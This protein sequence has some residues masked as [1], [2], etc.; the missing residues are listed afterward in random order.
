[1]MGIC[2]LGL[3]AQN[4]LQGVRE[5]DFKGFNISVQ[6]GALYSLNENAWTFNNDSKAT[7][8]SV[9]QAA[10]AA[11][12]GDY[13]GRTT[14]QGSISLGYDFGHALGIRLQGG[15]SMNSSAGNHNQDPTQSFHPYSFTAVTGYADAVFNISGFINPEKQHLFETKL[16]AGLGAA[17]SSLADD[18]YILPNE[19]TG[20]EGYE[21][22]FGK[23]VFTY[24]AGII[25]EMYISRHLG[26][27]IDLNIEALTDMFNGRESMGAPSDED[28]NGS[29]PYDIRLVGSFG[30]TFH[31]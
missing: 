9:L 12:K 18:R 29:F 3:M 26:A 17:K 5:R 1:M 22:D 2:S 25:E 23:A 19:E 20:Y 16:Y 13:T 28:K 15:Y 30:V 21:T 31:F 11:L 6:G 27:F 7:S 10:R 4:S 8:A 14:G 24:R